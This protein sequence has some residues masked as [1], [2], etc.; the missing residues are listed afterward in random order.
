M[1]AFSAITCQFPT[2]ASAQDRPRV[3]FDCDGRDCNSQYYRTEIVWVDWVNDR[4]VADVHLI[5][6]SLTTGAGGREYQLDFLGREEDDGYVDNMRYQALASDTDVERLDGV[7]HAMSIGLARFA[8]V[9]GFQRLATVEGVDP[10]E[11][12]AFDRVVS[13]QEVEDPWDLWVLRVNGNYNVEGESRRK[14]ENMFGSFS[15]TRISPTW[16]LNFSTSVNSLEQE[17]E[18]EQGTFTDT[19]TDW[20]V[21]P[22]LVYSLAEHWSVAVRGEVARQP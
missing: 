7:T 19:R 14:S 15:A 6:T 21:R 8:T 17:F 18:L 10:E 16:K 13:S 12:G 4:A 11:F 1:L 2:D 9:A 3:F 5:M 22:W 20:G